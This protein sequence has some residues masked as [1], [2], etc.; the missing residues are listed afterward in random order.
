MVEGNAHRKEAPAEYKLLPPGNV[1]V[2]S[3]KTERFR[4]FPAEG[5]RH[6]F[7]VEIGIIKHCVVPSD[8]IEVIEPK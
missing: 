7:K 2:V 5:T 8:K 1:A 6:S 3:G 4:L